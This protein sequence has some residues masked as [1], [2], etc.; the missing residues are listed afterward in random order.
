MVMSDPLSFSELHQASH[1][2]LVLQA[3]ALTGDPTAAA[4]GVRDAFVA[5]SRNWNKVSRFA[6]PEEW[7]R[8]RAWSMAHRRHLAKPW[9]RDQELT[10]EQ[11]AVL[12]GLQQLSDNQRRCLLLHTLVE[13]PMPAIGR[14]LGMT[15]SQ[16]IEL[17]H[18]AEQS[19][20][21]AVGVPTEE[22][23]QSLHL[24]E[25]L[26]TNAEVPDPADLQRSGRK[27]RAIYTVVGSV[28]AIAVFVGAGFLVSSG[29]AGP[30]L[31]SGGPDT[32]PVTQ[33]MLLIEPQ[34]E[35]LAPAQQWTINSTSDNTKG[36]GLNSICQTQRFADST[37]VGALVRKFSSLGVPAKTLV[38]SVEISKTPTAAKAAYETT[39]GW[40]A[41]CQA[42]RLRL[43]NSWRITGLGDEAEVMSFEIP[44]IGAKKKQSLMVS[45]ARSSSLMLS[46][47]EETANGDSTS[48]EVVTALLTDALGRLC[49]STAAEGKCDFNPELAIANPPPSGEAPGSLSVVDLPAVG[50]TMFPWLGSDLLPGDPNVA[51][52]PCDSTSFNK[53]GAIKANTR[54]YFIPQSGLPTR[55]GVT[56]TFA[57]MPDK[58]TANRVVNGIFAKMA[59]CEKDHL[60]SKVSQAHLEK[61]GPAG[62]SYGMWRVESQ[63]N[64]KQDT[65]VAWMGITRVGNYL[66][67]VN[68]TPAGVNDLDQ[69][70]FKALMQRARDRLHE[71]VPTEAAPIP[72]PQLEQKPAQ[73]KK[74]KKAAAQRP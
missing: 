14:E 8:N 71:V 55:F 66:A 32:K 52:T 11:A 73:K 50:K 54:S 36:T 38:E 49:K 61:N 44:G 63:I 60:G 21:R 43:Q 47:I 35:P 17:L 57:Q 62:S 4:A 42:P 28:A 22:T 51:S 3:I 12:R 64:D 5:A 27:Q 65:I 26:A 33:K 18:Q 41:G 46:L 25:S 37:G 72:E 20:A 39:R 53:V 24:L 16:A 1:Q 10:T 30:V 19:F 74:Q 58:R 40:Y 31:G 6:D 70:Q 23:K 69:A 48:P 56:E 2:R 7:V 34:L 29:A 13:L 15:E 45:M 67:Q 59:T 9:H 68:F